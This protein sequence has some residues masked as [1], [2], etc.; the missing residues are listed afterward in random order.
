LNLLSLF[1]S[2]QYKITYLILNVNLL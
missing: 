1:I 2:Q